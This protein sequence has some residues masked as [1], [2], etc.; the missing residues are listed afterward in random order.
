MFGGNAAGQVQEWLRVFAHYG[1]A[2]AAISL[3]QTDR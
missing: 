3:D 2:L 1:M